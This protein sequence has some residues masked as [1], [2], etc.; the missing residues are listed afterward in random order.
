MARIE[1]PAGD[2]D[3]IYRLFTL[4]PHLSGPAGAFS[5]AI[6]TKATLS[7]RLRELVRMRIADLNQCV[8]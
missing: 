6:Y 5:E 7:T 1:L 2:L 3:E 4:A 8:V